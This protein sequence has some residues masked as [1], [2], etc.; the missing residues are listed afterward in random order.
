MRR[1]K[2]AFSRPHIASDRPKPLQHRGFPNHATKSDQ[3]ATALRMPLEL[4][5]RWKA[6]TKCVINTVRWRAIGDRRESVTRRSRTVTKSG[7]TC[8]GS[9]GV[10]NGACQ[11]RCSST[12]GRPQTRARHAGGTGW[13]VGGSRE[14][15]RHRAVAAGAGRRRDGLRQ[16]GTVAPPL[17]QTHH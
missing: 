16:F 5:S 14:V 6:G 15:A 4:E 8:N 11:V 12:P 1:A 3:S 10:G 17:E 7:R 9:G 2:W 13:L